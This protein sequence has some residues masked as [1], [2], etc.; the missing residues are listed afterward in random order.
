MIESNREG[1]EI[2]SFFEGQRAAKQ[3]QPR[4]QGKMLGKK[5][6]RPV[7][8]QEEEVFGNIEKEGWLLKQGATRKV[9]DSCSARSRGQRVL[10]R[11]CWLDPNTGGLGGRLVCVLVWS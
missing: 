7:N 11:A 10:S 4:A 8:K 3:E 1:V 5:T 2:D 9:S 6:A